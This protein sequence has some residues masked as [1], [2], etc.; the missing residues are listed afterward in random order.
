[1]SNSLRGRAAGLAAAFALSLTL[2]LP[3]P[4]TAQSRWTQV[5][6]G[7]FNG[8]GQADIV[9]RDDAGRVAVQLMNGPQVVQSRVVGNMSANWTIVG[10]GDFNGDGKSDIRWQNNATGAVR[11]WQ[12]N[13]AHITRVSTF[14]GDMPNAMIGTVDPRNPST[15]TG[16]Y[17]GGS[18]G[19][20]GMTN[21]FT[22]AGQFS[23]CPPLPAIC[24]PDMT[25]GPTASASNS[26]VAG[27][28]VVGYRHL[29]LTESLTIGAEGFIGGGGG[30]I[31]F[32][33]I[34]G[35]FGTPGG[36]APAAGATGDSVTLTPG[37][38]GG[39][40]GQLGTTFRFG[41]VPIFIA[42]DAGVGFQHVNLAINCTGTMGACGAN[43]IPLQTLTTSTTL[44]GSLVGGEIDT[45]LG[46]I[47]PGGLNLSFL[48]NANVGFQF[49]HAD[50]G[51]FTTTLG[52]PAQIQLTTSQK[53]TTNSA[54]AKVTW[55]LADWGT[56]GYSLG[57]RLRY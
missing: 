17:M 27:N 57:D 31:K 49:F 34:P 15:W 32:T 5:G 44:V 40:V 30:D 3:Q 45:K 24:I 52:N 21:T 54:M 38:N 48:N 13:G 29:L 36:I 1:M 7:D 55:P 19:S 42:F 43:A 53:V 2:W 33:G 20:L 51:T 22:N 14:A 12:M 10:V 4:A 9:L 6:A 11:E 16:V 23:L 18:I 25:P 35:T 39:I 28:F 8:D 47:L 50:Y 26:G 37:W 41:S 56:G 46:A